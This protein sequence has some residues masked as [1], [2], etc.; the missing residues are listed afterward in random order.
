MKKRLICGILAISMLLLCACGE[1]SSNED[2]KL[3]LA[4]RAGVYS[5]VIKECLPQ[6]EELYNV[7]CEVKEFSEEEL[8]QEIINDSL[9]KNGMYDICMVDGSWVGQFFAE[10][11]LANLSEYNY[12]LDED[13]IPATTAICKQG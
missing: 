8:R 6:F 9:N 13:I 2:N 3:V 12:V 7:E 5:E 1:E 10:S 11:V 4:L